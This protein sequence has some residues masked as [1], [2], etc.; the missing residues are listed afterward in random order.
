[1]NKSSSR[2]PRGA[3]RW[4]RPA[5]A[6][7]GVVL[8]LVLGACSSSST[9]STPAT[10]PSPGTSSVTSSQPAPSR[11]S[12]AP[13]A[14]ASVPTV[15]SAAAIQGRALCIAEG[16]SMPFLSQADLQK[17]VDGIKNVAHANCVRFDIDRGV[18]EIAPGVFDW[19]RIDNVVNTFERNG[20]KVLGLLDGTPGWAF[21]SSCP[22]SQFIMCMPTWTQY[23][24]FARA[25]ILRYEPKPGSSVGIADWEVWNEPNLAGFAGPAANVSQYLAL[26][27]PLYL[28]IHKL[29]PGAVVISGGLGPSDTTGG[30]I[31]PVQFVTELFQL[32][33][34]QYLDALGDHPY[35]YPLLA[36]DQDPTNAWQQMQQLHQII[37]SKK[38]W[39]TEDGAPAADPASQALQLAILNSTYTQWVATPW[40]QNLFWMAYADDATQTGDAGHLGLATAALA[41]KLALAQFSKDE[42]ALAAG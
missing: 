2:R 25:A 33:G 6:A 27:K 42:L 29:E 13:T 26:L 4:R 30:S 32:H 14:S 1:M 37:G 11:Q 40:V 38:I 41:P 7:A 35:S 36:S 5:G 9:T 21:T 31:S 16:G 23:E 10:A 19:T 22:N 17:V 34:G 3:P 8:A 12:Q 28:M 18:V 20:I 39:A 15:V 24:P